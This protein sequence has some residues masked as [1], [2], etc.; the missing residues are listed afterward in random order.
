LRTIHEDSA[1]RPE[2]R[3]DA[4]KVWQPTASV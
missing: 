3:T 1:L 4:R 2:L